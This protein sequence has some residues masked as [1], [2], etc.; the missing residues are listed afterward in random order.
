M[1]DDTSH[2]DWKPR[3]DAGSFREIGSLVDG[4]PAAAWPAVAAERSG[5][6]RAGARLFHTQCLRQTTKLHVTLRK[7]FGFGSAIMAMNPFDAQTRAGRRE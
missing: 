4:A 6:L 2:N 3:L 7:A 5:A 1:A